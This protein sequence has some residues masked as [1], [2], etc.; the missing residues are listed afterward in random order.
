MLFGAD[1]FYAVPLAAIIGLPLYITTEA[2]IPMIQSMIQS[3]ASQGAMLAFLI[4]GSATSAWVIA[5][6]TSFMRKRAVSIYVMFIL[7]GGIVSGY[8]LDL[9]NL[10]I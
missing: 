10:F 5:G 8:V 3:G 1:S 9:I 6:L 2:G 4:T 7:V